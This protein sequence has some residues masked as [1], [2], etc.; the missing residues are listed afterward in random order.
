MAVLDL[1]FS[2]TPASG[3]RKLAS[4]LH[5]LPA[6]ARQRRHLASLDDVRLDD[7]GLTRKAA[8]NEARRPIWD[9]PCHWQRRP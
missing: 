6:L 8:T 3:F 9:V 2:A 7:L 5:L 1:T 4:T